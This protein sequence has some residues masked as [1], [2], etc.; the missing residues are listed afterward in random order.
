MRRRALIGKIAGVAIWPIAAHSQ[1]KAMPLIGFLS[2]GAVDASGPNRAAFHGGLREA[3]FV[4]GQNVTVEYRHAEGRFERLPAMAADLVGRKVDV[5]VCGGTQATRAAKAATSAIPIVFLIGEDP[6]AEGFVASLA[7]P[8]GNLTGS[9]ILVGDLYPKRLELLREL[10]PRAERIALLVDP[11]TLSNQRVLPELQDAA[12][13]KG[14]GLHIVRATSETEI[15]GAFA[16]LTQLQADALFVTADQF[17][18]SRREQI[19]ALAARHAVPAIYATRDFTTVGGLISYGPNLTAAIRESGGYAGRI[20]KGASPAD[21]PVIQPTR[22]ELVINLKTAH[23][24]GLTIP[25]AVLAR[26]DEV[27]E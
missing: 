19:V 4:E 14:L 16:S 2:G 12:R 8:S 9:S 5:I 7:R 25:P 18:G 20:L 27:V 17:F 13:A 6:V 15:D 1:Q 22:F 24:L 26:A 10:L 11:R 21:L 3:G 23:A